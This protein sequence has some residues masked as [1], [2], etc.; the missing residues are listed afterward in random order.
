MITT[1]NRHQTVPIRRD[2]TRPGL[3]PAASGRAAHSLVALARAAP[4]P[5][6]ICAGLPAGTVLIALAYANAA[7]AGGSLLHF[8]LFW[9][10][11]MAF[12]APVCLRLC[13]STVRRGERLALLA[14]TGLFSFL[15][16][17]LR[18]PDGPLFH[19]ELAHW[20]QAE[21]MFS[22]GRLFLPNPSVYISQFFPGL[23]TMTVAL[24]HLTGLSTFQVAS[25]L[26][27][28][29]HAAA[30]FGIF[31]LV[32]RLTG[33]AVTAG[34]AGFLYALNPGF[35]FF[36]AQYSYESIAFVFVIWVVVAAVNVQESA[37]DRPQRAAWLRT[38][39]L[40]AAACVVTHHLSS[41][42][43]LGVLWLM[44]AVAH[45]RARRTPATADGAAVDPR[46]IT[47]FALVATLLA[48]VW[49]VW[50][51]PP[52][53]TYL[54]SPFTAALDQLTNLL[55][56]RQRS[57]TLF[58]RSSTPSYERLCAFATIAIV[59]AA[60]LLGLALQWRRRPRST[61][62]ISLTLFAL[63]YF[64]SL[65]LMLTGAGNEGARRS[66]TFSYI[67]LCLV[68]APALIWVLQRAREGGDR[69][70]RL[71]AAAITVLLMVV[72]IGNVSMNINELYRFP[73]PYIYGSDTRSTTAEL[74]GTTQWLRRTQGTG[75][76][77][78]ADRYSSQLLAS[79][80]LQWTPFASAAFPIWQLYFDPAAPSPALLRELRASDYR[81]LVVDGRMA[82]ALPY[83]G[84][85]FA[86]QETWI[87]APDRPPSRAVIDRFER[88]PWAIKI[89]QSDNLAIYRLNFAAHAPTFRPG[90]RTR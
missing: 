56:H 17:Y 74:L 55:Q 25:I 7:V 86:D 80:G 29:T 42:L 22:T 12:L 52:V 37:N 59:G 88:L 81:Y 6:L 45:V 49:L 23:Q 72:A 36:D 43:M 41:Y 51:A 2:E 58:A 33:S 89:Y 68:I 13:D 44:A 31:A 53:I 20:R 65:P 15:P 50:V 66:W 71:A 47:R 3:T 60:T 77:V 83:L 35:M 32:E 63:L 9:I 27:V 61:P 4:V 69:A 54:T 73:G 8:H 84:S 16:K 38:G 48:A 18:T 57:R 5:L 40:L 34:I 46:P 64:A 82:R 90:G 10:G 85:Y 87:G 39:L 14:A 78:A 70:R 19:D 62:S 30:L 26:I 21:L 28:S 76:G 1:V 24:R 75:H 67:G 11:V 79:F